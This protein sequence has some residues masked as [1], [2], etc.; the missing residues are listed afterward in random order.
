MRQE[1]FVTDRQ[2]EGQ[3]YTQG[4]NSISNSPSERGYNK[5]VTYMRTY[6]P[7]QLLL[8]THLLRKKNMV[9]LS[10]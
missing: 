4:Q 6:M 7:Q 1:F 2:T 10:Q 3:T 9:K 5:A 8:L